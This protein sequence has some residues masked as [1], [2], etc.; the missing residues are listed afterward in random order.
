MFMYTNSL[1]FIYR[2]NHQCLMSLCICF[3]LFVR[4]SR[5]L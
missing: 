2:Y 3:V 1:M 4:C 5:H